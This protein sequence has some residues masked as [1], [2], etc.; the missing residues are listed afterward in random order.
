TKELLEISAR[1]I[2]AA[3]GA[4]RV[5]P[6]DALDGDAVERHASNIVTERGRID[7]SFNAIGLGD[8]QG[9]PL[10]EMS[11]EQFAL[12]I[13]TAMRSHFVTATAAAR[14]M[15][16][17]K[18]GVILA[19]TAQTSRKPHANVGGFGV[20]GTAIEGFCRPLG[21]GLCPQGLRG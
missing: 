17:K 6:V 12:P 14:H 4:C 7:I 20:A 3:G 21:V 10:L 1:D 5:V 9:A 15:S 16:R 18:S 8:T 2:S 13:V 11:H 19:I